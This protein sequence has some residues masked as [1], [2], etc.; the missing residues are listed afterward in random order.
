M[1]LIYDR[2]LSPSEHKQVAEWA[3]TEFGGGFGGSTGTAGFTGIEGISRS[4]GT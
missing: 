3:L 2:C 1:Y 4:L